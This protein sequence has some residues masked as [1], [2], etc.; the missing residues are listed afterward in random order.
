MSQIPAEKLKELLIEDHLISP[1]QFDSFLTEANR[2]GQEITDVLVSKNIVTEK[3]LVGLLSKYFG[4]KRANISGV[5]L[6]E[7]VVRLLPEDIA[8]ARRVVVFKKNE[9]GSLDVAME[10][11]SDLE[12]VEFLGSFLKNSIN[13]FLATSD[14]L[15]EAYSIYNQKFTKDF[16]DII[17][18]NIRASMLSKA[19][20][21]EEAA[22]DLPIVALVNNIVSYAFSLGASD[23]HIE[24][25]ESNILIR[26]RVDGILREV[27]RIPRD[28]LLP[29]IARIKL[30][31]GLKLDE[32]MKPQDGRFRYK[33]GKEIIDMRVSIM[34]TFHGEKAVLRLLPSTQKPMSLEEL[35]IDSDNIPAVKENIKKSFGMIIVCGPTGSG[36][37]TTLYSILNILNT[38][39]VNIV[40]IED[41]IEYEIKYVNQ[42]QINERAGITFANGLRSILRQDPNIILVGEV[43]DEETADISVNAALT[44]HLLLSSLHTNDAPTAIPRL[45]DMK[46]PAFLISAVLNVIIAQRLV[47]KICPSC[48]AS[49]S[50]DADIV[51]SIKR[52]LRQIDPSIDN[53][54]IPKILYRGA[55]CPVCGGTGYKGRIGIFE[56]LNISEHIRNLITDPKFSLDLLKS[57]AKKEGM[58]TMFEDG[59]KKAELGATT[60]EEILRVIRE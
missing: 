49:Y 1:E 22:A 52:E 19:K 34:P 60:I 6:E 13:T 41:P 42:T 59:V 33:I 44:G 53:P 30:L 16:K 37:T 55:G 18:E 50:P 23:I 9:N 4:V 57:E 47:R 40:T 5:S 32:H 10:N 2:L 46:I 39:E 15:N 35:G 56:I 29:V 45:L 21:L 12:T 8:R 58:K 43:R 51:S 36:K 7:S 48:V 11:P 20:G 27:M 31:A 3:Y 54:K 24:P 14:D 28:V 25:L 38:P 17:E 26:Y